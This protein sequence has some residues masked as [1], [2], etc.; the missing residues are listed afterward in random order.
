MVRWWALLR[1]REERKQQGGKES[2]ALMDRGGARMWIGAERGRIMAGRGCGSGRSKDD[3]T[4]MD[5]EVDGTGPSP[6]LFMVVIDDIL[7]IL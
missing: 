3:A 2:S 7:Y 4:G 1:S 5:S 6:S